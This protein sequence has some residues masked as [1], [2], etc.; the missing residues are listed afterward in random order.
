MRNRKWNTLRQRLRS[1]RQSLSLYQYCWR[2]VELVWTTDRSLTVLLAALTL[3][4]GLLPAV[5]AYL[6]KLIVDGVVLAA[7][8]GTSA[9]QWV[10]LGYLG[11]EAIAVV[12]LAGSKQGL[13]LCQSLLRAL[14]GQK[15]NVLI[16]EKALTLDMAHFE[17]S[18]F[19]DKMTR[20]RR[21][22]SSRPLSLVGRTFGLVQDALSLVTYG[23]LLLRFSLW[24]VLI[25]MLAAIPAFIAETRFAG[26]AFRLFRWRAPE[27]RQQTYLETLLA[28]EDSATEV[29]LYQLGPMLLDRYRNIFRQ[30]YAED[31]DL[32]IRRAIWSYLLGLLST[33]AFYGAYVWIVLEAIAGRIS[34]GDLTMYLV[35]F[36]QGQAAF[37][38]ALTR[39]SGMYEDS[40]YLSNL[41]EFLEEDIPEPM[42][43]ATSGSLPGDGLRFENVSFTYAGNPKPALQGVT[44]HL[45]PG[46]KMAIVGENGSGKTT[47]IKLLT[48]L[49]TPDSGRIL[50]DGLDLQTWDVAVLQRRIGVIFQNFVRYQFIVGENVGVGDVEYLDDAPRWEIAAQ[51]GTAYPFIE[52]MPEGF[53][54][55]LGKWFKG[56][57][58][59][60]GGQWQKVALSRAFMRSQADILVLDEPTSAMDAEAEVQIFD[61]FRAMTEQQMAIL[62]SHRFSTVR[63]ADQIIVLSNGEL[64]EQ[65]THEALLAAG[66]RYARLFSL[67]A[68]GYR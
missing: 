4:G 49:Y 34:L 19:Y 12:L 17:D 3:V 22:A 65:G 43:T 52:E 14:M 31:R 23:A 42:G 37:S 32:S 38:S 57:R 40:L 18:E 53:Q 46:E 64:I 6:G 16:L 45:K 10:A 41:Y 27:A 35:V 21:E 1:L 30:L 44:F 13:A 25:L 67:Q 50:L 20:A 54:T 60:S 8:S 39:I 2:A 59:L 11:L 33:A 47:L 5:V 58:E 29:K 36:R 66:G 56:G 15:V 62:I 24:A 26:E 55:Q 51:K 9:D 68:A 63:M 7:G 28:R 48:R 61:R